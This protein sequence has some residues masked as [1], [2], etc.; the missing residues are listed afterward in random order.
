MKN[1]LFII[2]LF[3]SLSG[4][5]GCKD[6]T[7]DPEPVKEFGKIK[8]I[9]THHVDGL[10]L[11][12][13][14]MIYTNAAGNQYEVDQ[15]MYF[16]SDV[17]LHNADGSVKVINGWKDIDYID[18]DIP[19]T[20]S[21]DVYDDIPAGTYNSVSFTFGIPEAKNITM[22]FVN[23][24]EVNMM[25][26]GILGGGYH[27]MM[28]N[29]KWRDTANVIQN[30]AFH[31][32]IGQLYHSNVINTDSI[33]A[34]VQNYFNVELPNSSFTI[35]KDKT[36][37]IEIVMNIDSWFK[38][39]GVYDHNYWGSGIMQNQPAMQMIKDNGFDVFTTGLIQ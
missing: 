15:L 31:L 37:Q 21:W 7:I 8:F 11:V 36:R 6:K 26:P 16:I 1:R 24:P 5:F 39:P 22:M 4:L 28:M 32:G 23:P 20:L 25:W 29:G 17:T 34:F 18:D 35:E 19:S 13:D 2:A 10:P 14:T 12:K 9:F 33:Y 27:Y 30:F 3:V 38:T